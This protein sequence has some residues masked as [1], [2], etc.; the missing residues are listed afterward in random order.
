MG[1]TSPS[2]TT[3]GAPGTRTS[4]EALLVLAAGGWTVATQAVAVAAQAYAATVGLA[5]ASG[6]ATRMSIYTLPIGAF[7]LGVSIRN[8]IDHK[9]DDESEARI[10]AVH[11]IMLA[12]F[13][14]AV[15]RHFAAAPDSKLRDESRKTRLILLS[16]DKYA[17]TVIRFSTTYSRWADVLDR[18]IY[19]Q[20]YEFYKARPS[21]LYGTDW[22][23]WV[24]VKYV[25]IK[26][27]YASILAEAE[28]LSKVR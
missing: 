2:E 8:W 17:A 9:D 23:D 26:A 16:E 1:V 24:M 12:A 7:M 28:Q 22:N 15:S 13:E 10:A 5:S 4:N 14:D 18:E 27:L 19:Q 25:T 11:I 3:A 6:M 21:P 20:Q